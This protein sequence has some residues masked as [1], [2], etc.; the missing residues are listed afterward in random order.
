MNEITKY[1]KERE[2]EFENRY[3]LNFWTTENYTGGFN[4]IKFTEWQRWQKNIA[5]F[6]MDQ[7]KTYNSQTLKG[8]ISKIIEENNK[9]KDIESGYRAIEDINN[10]LEEILK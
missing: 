2:E 3:P 6:H 10:S 4:E 5:L 1:I 8:L 7:V 9:R